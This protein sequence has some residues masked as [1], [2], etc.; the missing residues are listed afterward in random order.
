MVEPD[1]PNPTPEERAAAAEA[2]AAGAVARYRELVAS[3]PDLVP[4][5]V[6]GATVEEIDASAEA[7]RRAYAEISRSVAARYEADVLPGNPARSGSAP[8]ADALPPEA[9]IAL[10]LRKAG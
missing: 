10:G 2:T 3:A 6:Q 4:G 8:G 7:A 1:N 9:K 5:M